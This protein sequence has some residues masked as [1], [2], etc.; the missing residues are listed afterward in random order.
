[1]AEGGEVPIRLLNRGGGKASVWQLT[2][3]GWQPAD[4]TVN[5]HYLLLTMAGTTATFCVRSTQGGP[6]LLVLLAAALL[7][8]LA[9][10]LLVVRHR[11]KKKTAGK[12]V[13]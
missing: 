7:A 5:G 3:G 10:I 6:W 4:V 2:N 8:V 11:K 13:K 12:A 1:M 9:A